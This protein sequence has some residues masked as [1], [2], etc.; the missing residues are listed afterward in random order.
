MSMDGTRRR[1]ATLVG[2][3]LL[4]AATSSANDG[5][6]TNQIRRLLVAADIVAWEPIGAG[7]TGAWRVTLSDGTMTHDAAFQPV[8]LTR[9][10]GGEGRKPVVDSFRHSIAAYRLAELVGLSE[11]MPITVERTWRGR[12][13]AL[14]WWI[15]DVA[16]DEQARSEA[17]T[18]PADLDAWGAQIDQM[19]LFAELV[20]D[21]D[22]HRGNLLYTRDWQLYMVDFTRAFGLS[23]ELMKPYRL[24]RIDPGLL[25]RLEK[26]TMTMVTAATA[27]YLSAEQVAAVLGRRDILVDYFRSLRQ[28]Q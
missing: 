1:V 12:P 28:K 5:L 8:D 9:R 11:M 18:F 15:D 26:L 22:R 19:W 6:S 24:L 3:A 20:H 23:R 10:G 13:G 16:F 4:I 7:V 27:P 21:T 14:S 17:R 2:T 25:S